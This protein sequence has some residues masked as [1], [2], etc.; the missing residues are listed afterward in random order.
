MKEHW[1]RKLRREMEELRA[2]IDELQKEK[3][4]FK[5]LFLRKAAEFENY[6]KV[7]KDEWQKNIDFANERIIKSLISVLDHFRLALN[8]PSNDEVFRKGVEM[9]YNE[10]LQVL[11]H[12]G[13]EIIS[14]SGCSFDENFHEAIDVVETNELPPGTV[15]DEIQPGYV[16]KGKVIRPARVRVSKEKL[17]KN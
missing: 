2:R 1:I 14:G 3:E 4:D 16:L 7:M 10:L 12:E 11:R 13:L 6:K 9:I 17:E 8:T 5:E 15:V